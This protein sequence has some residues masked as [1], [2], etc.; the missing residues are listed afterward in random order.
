MSLNFFEFFGDDDSESIDQGT[1]KSKDGKDKG[2]GKS[3]TRQGKDAP[4]F[5]ANGE[6]WQQH[7]QIPRTPAPG[8]GKPG[9]YLE[10]PVSFHVFVSNMQGDLVRVDLDPPSTVAD[11]IGDCVDAFAIK[12]TGEEQ[13]GSIDDLFLRTVEGRV[14][15][16]TDMLDAVVASGQTVVIESGP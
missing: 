6:V 8:K 1:G 12:D 3:N 13:F 9:K 10:H 14:L 5:H 16:H 15:Q 2:K 11:F 7:W 4:Y